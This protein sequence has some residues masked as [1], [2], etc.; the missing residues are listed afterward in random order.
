MAEIFVAD[1]EHGV[2]GTDIRAGFIK[3]AADE[4]GVNPNVEKV[5]RAVARASVQTGRRSWPTRGPPRA[6]AA[7]R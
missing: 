2:Q 7:S 3:C 1:L 5:H 4:P 6:P